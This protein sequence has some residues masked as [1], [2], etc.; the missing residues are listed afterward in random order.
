M[1]NL[2]L[3]LM[4]FRNL[5]KRKTRTFLTIFGV[6]IGS[7]SVVIMLSLGIA[8]KYTFTESIQSLEDVRVLEIYP[9]SR[10]GEQSNSNA[11][12]LDD[13]AIEK[14]KKLPNVSGASPIAE[15]TL[16]AKSG[17]LVSYLNVKGIDPEQVDIFNFKISEGELLPTNQVNDYYVIMFGSESLNSFYDPNDRRWGSKEHEYPLIDV[18]NDKIEASTEY[19]FIDVT[20]N[21]FDTPEDGEK[22]IIKPLKIKVSG[23]L[24]PT[25]DFMIDHYVFMDIKS[26][27]KLEQERLE[28]IA[29][30]NNNPKPKPNREYTEAVV[31][32]SNVSHVEA[33]K[34]SIEDL[35]FYAQSSFLDMLQQVNYISLG[36]QLFLGAIGLIAFIIA[37]T[38][39]TN[40]MVMAM[41][42]RRKEIGIMKVIGASLKDIKRLFVFESTCIGFIGGV[43]GLSFSYLTSYILNSIVS[44]LLKQYSIDIN[45]IKLSVIPLWLGPSSILFS[46][47]VGLVAGYFP[48]KKAMKLSA[49]SAIRTE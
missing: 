18:L 5:F 23:L 4:S 3:I 24:E 10:F 33:V 46:C 32:A 39:I 15:S 29:K 19:E 17:K 6:C 49:L 43:I 7:S 13:T 14:F 1:S 45:T 12:M 35:G 48:A 27:I 21:M 2:D 22:K 9:L 42:E 8:I 20:N 30:E 37:A 34:Q 31:K 11:G 36:V 47:F 44:M 28:K 25:D 26:I 16:Y 38:G 40:T 41:Y